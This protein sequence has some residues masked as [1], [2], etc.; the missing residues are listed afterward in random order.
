[1]TPIHS[2][3]ALLKDDQLTLFSSQIGH[4]SEP[5]LKA[6]NGSAE[7]RLKIES[8][9]QY[10]K[11]EDITFIDKREQ[12]GIVWALYSEGAKSKM[13]SFFKKMDMTIVLEKRGSTSTGNKPAWRIMIK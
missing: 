9:I 5:L 10:L 6:P 7:N 4:R 13:E 11:A 3:K 8:I 2:Q 1:V 12:S